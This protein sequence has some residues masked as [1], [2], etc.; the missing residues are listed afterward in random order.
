MGEIIIIVS[1]VLVFGL[2]LFSGPKETSAA[3]KFIDIMHDTSRTG[4]KRK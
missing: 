4:I 1:V 3:D 2:L